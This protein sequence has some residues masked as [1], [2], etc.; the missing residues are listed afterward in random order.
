MSVPD[1]VVVSSLAGKTGDHMV[2]TKGLLSILEQGDEALLR[3]IHQL[4][5]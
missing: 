1:D 3:A 5:L 2:H 4:I